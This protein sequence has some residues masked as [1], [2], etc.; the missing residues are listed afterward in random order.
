MR[1][2]LRINYSR[3]ILKIFLNIKLNV[4]ALIFFALTFFCTNLFF[5]LTMSRRASTSTS[6]SIL[7]PISSVE[8]G[9]QFEKEV[10]ENLKFIPNLFCKQ[11]K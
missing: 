8:K 6:T 11:V 1:E 10:L 7:T 9:N 2:N 3:T 5:V 4:F